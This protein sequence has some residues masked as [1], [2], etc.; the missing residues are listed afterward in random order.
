[1][2][3]E[4]PSPETLASA[5]ATRHFTVASLVL[6]V[7]SVAFATLGQFTL[8]AAMNE[9]GA[10]TSAGH[11][12]MRAARIP[13]LWLGLALFGIS[14][15]FWL[16]VLSKVPLSVAYPFV[17]VSYIVVVLVSRFVLHEHVPG[18]RW[19]GVAV[20]AAGIALVGFSFRRITGS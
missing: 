9:V 13:K 11:T 18:L 15:V 6:I 3:L 14:A 20:V 10:H 5:Q 17:G 2:V 8:K 7:V 1:M 12:L 4:V 16:L 19:L